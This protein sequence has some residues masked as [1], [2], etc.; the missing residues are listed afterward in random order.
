MLSVIKNINDFSLKN[1]LW[2]GALDTLKVIIEN[3][4]FQDLM[5]LL[6]EMYPEP[7]EIT[8]I[9]DLLWFD[10]D[11]IYEQLGIEETETENSYRRV[12]K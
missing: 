8:T 3:N 1:E 10:D 7:V 5:C 9:N 2:C 11:Y 4:K 12:L 6:E